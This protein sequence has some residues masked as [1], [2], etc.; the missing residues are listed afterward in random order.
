MANHLVIMAGGVGS[1]FWPLS[2]DTRPK[3]FLD[4]LGCGKT[5]IQLTVE[6]FKGLIPLE[7]V[8]VVTSEAFRDL[9]AEQLP[10]IPS[11]NLLFEPCRRNTA[12]CI[13][14]ASWKIKK[15]DPRANIVVA[16][17]D[18]IIA[19]VGKFQEAVT[20]ALDFAIETDAIVTLGMRPTYPE[21]GYGYIKA[22]F[23]YSSS[24]KKNIFRVD[25]FKEK[26]DHDTAEEYLREGH[27]LWNS[28]LF[29]W[30]VSTIINAF[31]VYEPAISRIF[32]GLL[33]YYDTPEEQERL[34]Q[35][36]PECPTISV[37]YAILE[38]AEEIF[39]YPADF[40]W[41]D[42]GT[43]SSLRANVPQDKY[44]NATIGSGIDL[45]E[46]HGNIIHATSLKKVVVQ[47]LDGYVV[48]EHDGTLLICK[49]TEEQ[50]IK[51]FH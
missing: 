32:E 21:T 46:S 9:I 49:L 19:D 11:Q 43:W 8:W 6:R 7:N 25:G 24:R 12:P 40:G 47:G 28:G 17:S 14:Y 27:F 13:C 16:P 38:K 33:P 34:D 39:V 15:R 3:Q 31:R 20:D 10:D 42:L 22:D 41:S 35:A 37:D 45:Y 36:F 44:G 30:S 5:L 1:R 50:R 4:V 29:V 18:H 48:A 51:L 23:S 26:P 2:N